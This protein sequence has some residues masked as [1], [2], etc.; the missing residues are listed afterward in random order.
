MAW[1]SDDPGGTGQ[2][3]VLVVVDMQRFFAA[4]GAWEV[5]GFE[6]LIEPVDRLVR[7]YGDRAIFTRF[8]VPE[9]PAG[10][11]ID[12]YQEWPQVCGPGAKAHADLVPPWTGQAW[13]LIDAPRFSKWGPELAAA[14][15]PAAPLAVCGVST[16]CCVL[17]TAL[18]AADAGRHVRVIS[19]ACAGATPEAHQQALA[20]LAYFAPQV[21]ICSVAEE[22]ERLRCSAA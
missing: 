22:L 1:T 9:D 4:G 10:S 2:D 12:Y 7:C 14:V 18:A 21:T 8:V 16:E 3:A 5:P 20:I 17:A 13:R 19:D 6:A 15:G 11:W